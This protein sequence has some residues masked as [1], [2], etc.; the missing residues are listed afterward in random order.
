MEDVFDIAIR[1]AVEV[2]DKVTLD[3]SHCW[4]C[5]KPKTY[6]CAHCDECEA[7]SE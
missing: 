7:E 3:F 6:P 5:G 2:P 1:T 4:N